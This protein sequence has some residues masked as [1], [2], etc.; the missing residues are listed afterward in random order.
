MWQAA[1]QAAAL[2]AADSANLQRIETY[3]DAIRTLKAKFEQ[4]NPDGG[5]A[6]GDVYL[7]RPGRMRFQYAPPV[8]MEIVSNGDYVAVDNKELKQV[9]FLPGLL[10]PHLVSAARG[11]QA[12]G[13]R[14]GHQDRP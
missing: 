5:T 7:S 4:F 10:D 3:L 11:H 14:N 8:Q 1:T 9:N 2:T 12:F 13:R 6:S